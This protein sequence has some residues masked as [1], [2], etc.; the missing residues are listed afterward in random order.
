MT[1]FTET[2]SDTFRRVDGAAAAHLNSQQVEDALSTKFDILKSL[3]ADER[4]RYYLARERG[5]QNVLLIKALA[6]HIAR[7]PRQ[8]ELFCLESYAGSKLSH[9]NVAKTGRP[10]K[11]DGL[12]FCAVENK[13]DTSA[14]RELLDRN[15]W[16]ALD[17][18]V[19]IADQIASALDHA[20]SLGV[21]HLQLQPESILVEPSGLV[22]VKD[23]GIES[24]AR[25]EWAHQE[26]TRR[27]R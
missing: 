14:L 21:L 12:Y 16:L 13:Q 10:Q 1:D 27:R 2:T 23:F 7:D 24:G 4:A 22:T 8:R 18:A 20:H 3:G 17:R 9:F 19:E 5:F 15:G 25:L 11:L 6:P 26:R